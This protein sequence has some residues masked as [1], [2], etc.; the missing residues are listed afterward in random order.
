M[1]SVDE[2]DP[3]R[4]PVGNHTALITL[5][6]TVKRPVVFVAIFIKIAYIHIAT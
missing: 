2:I 4:L 3:F 1:L 5:Y 6:V